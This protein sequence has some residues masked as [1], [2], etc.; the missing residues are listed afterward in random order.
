MLGEKMPSS[1]R[2]PCCQAKKPKQNPS[3]IPLCGQTWRTLGKQSGRYCRSPVL[4]PL[5]EKLLKLARHCV[6]LMFMPAWLW[7]GFGRASC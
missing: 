5:S 1:R 4:S 7:C 2:L 3:P 6:G